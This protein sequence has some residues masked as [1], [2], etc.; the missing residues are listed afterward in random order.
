MHFLAL[1]IVLVVFALVMVVAH[2]VLERHY[3]PPQKLA[4]PPPA[5]VPTR[6]KT[7]PPLDLA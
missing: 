5:D 7:P 1:G 6:P 4:P 2:T 3:A